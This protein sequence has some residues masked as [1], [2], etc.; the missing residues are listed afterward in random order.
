[1]FLSFFPN[2]RDN[3][4]EVPSFTQNAEGRWNFDFNLYSKMNNGPL[5]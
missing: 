4:L 5:F 3:L 1:M 2:F